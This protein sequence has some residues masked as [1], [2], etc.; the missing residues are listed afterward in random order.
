MALSTYLHGGNTRTRVRRSSRRRKNADRPLTVRIGGYRSALPGCRRSNMRPESKVPAKEDA[1]LVSRVTRRAT[2]KDARVGQCPARRTTAEEPVRLS[3]RERRKI[4]TREA[5]LKAA[6]EVIA[7]KGVYFAVIEEIT[8]R[9]DVAKGSFYQYFRDRDDLLHVLLSRRLEELRVLIDSAPP[10][11]TVTERVQTLIHHHVEYFLR[12]EDFLLFLH[13]I[14][15]LIKTRGEETPAVR[16][17][18]R[19]H[20]LFLAERLRPTNSKTSVNSDILTERACV[21]L[22]LLTGF[23][24][25]Y[26]MLSPLAKLADNQ[27]RIETAMTNS[28]LGFWQ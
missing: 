24:S 14:R 2:Q 28:C 17:V 23:L 13:Q 27:A 19:H 18:Y 8:E 3:R 16:E 11:G 1:V 4:A 20:L 22:G 12:H 6:Q 7:V 9:A 25:H 10:S 15:G 26:A 21:L 5:L